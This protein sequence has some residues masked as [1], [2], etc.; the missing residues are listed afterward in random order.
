MSDTAYEYLSGNTNPMFL[1]VA[2][3][4]GSG[5]TT[6]T[7][8]LAER[9]NWRPHFESV[10]DNPYLSDFYGDMERWSFPLQV[11][12]LTHRFNTHQ[13][14]EKGSASSIQDRS[15][16]ED[17]H[18]FARAL[19]EQGDLSKR[20]YENYL[21]LYQSMIQYLNPPTLTIFLKR[22]IPKLQ[23]RIQMRGRDYEQ[24]IPVDYLTKLNHY[25]DEWYDSYSQGKS[26]LVDTDDLDFLEN[27]EHFDQLVQKIYSSID[28]QD[29]FFQSMF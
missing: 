6:L 11:Y 14:I 1:V 7:R 15:I 8:K 12:F 21:T 16:Y 27:E 2:G 20:D 25:Y 10:T 23:E 24:S 19:F 9:L 18:I 28:Q 22:S 26:L 3:N 5:K 4:I 13:E 17:A 29:M